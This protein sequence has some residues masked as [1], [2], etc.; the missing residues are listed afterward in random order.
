M[1]PAEHCDDKVVY[2]IVLIGAG[3]GAGQ[4][5]C[6]DSSCGDYTGESADKYLVLCG[7]CVE[8]ETIYV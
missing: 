5:I 3:G 1:S 8:A 2:F 7:V 4:T 6:G